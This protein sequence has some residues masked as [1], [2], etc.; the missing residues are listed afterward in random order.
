MDD[1]EAFRQEVRAWIEQS[2]PPSMRSP[3]TDDEQV[4]GGRHAVFP[5]PDS[6]LWLTRMVE[7]GFIAPTWPKEYGGAGLSAEEAAVLAAELR[8]A[9]CR[10]ALRSLGLW[11]LGPVILRFGTE[12]QKREHL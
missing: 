11:M 9:G 10:V 7:R 5:H 1:L 4:W 6:K 8:R 3:G 12:E 2:C